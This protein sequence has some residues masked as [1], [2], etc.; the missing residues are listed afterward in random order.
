M[1]SP[2]YMLFIHYEKA[3][4]SDS[5]D[6]F[7][8]ELQNIGIPDKIISIIRKSYDNLNRTVLHQGKLSDTFQSKSGVNQGCLLPPLLFLI[9][10][11][12]DLNGVDKWHF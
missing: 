5:R 11:G 2:L 4:D 3:F 10:I 6:C 12:A 1:R 9:E 8:M 7:W